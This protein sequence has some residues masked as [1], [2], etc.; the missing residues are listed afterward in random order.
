MNQPSI[1]KGTRDFIPTEMARRNFIFAVMRR[2]F[3]RFGF[4]PIETPSFENI[5][6]LTGK[7]GDEGDQ[8]IFKILDNGDYLKDVSVESL[9][10]KN[11][12]E[13]TPQISSRALRY[14]LTVPFARGGT[15]CL[16][17]G[18][19]TAKQAL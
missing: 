17:G 4:A 5:A 2:H 6:T 3:E 19:A 11:L 8:L 13:I 1:P 12:N 9:T 16:G 15:R 10:S 7:Y 14:D 18:I